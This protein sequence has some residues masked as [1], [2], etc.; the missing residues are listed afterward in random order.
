MSGV[1]RFRAGPPACGLPRSRAREV[2]RPAGRVNP[3]EQPDSPALSPPHDRRRHR[4]R[5]RR[6][7]ADPLPSPPRP[8]PSP[9]RPRPC[10]RRRHRAHQGHPLLHH[11]DGLD[12]QSWSTARRSS[13]PLTARQVNFVL[14]V[15]VR[16]NSR[17]PPLLLYCNSR[18]RGIWFSSPVTS[19]Q[20]K[21]SRN[22]ELQ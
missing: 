4:C 3:R 8:S 10:R 21:T 5:R 17:L 18:R 19:L 6:R 11:G 22:R 9:P 14:Y 13:A 20:L 15:C 16:L 12:R 2:P 1:I 7:P